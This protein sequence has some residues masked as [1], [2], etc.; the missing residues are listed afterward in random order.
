MADCGRSG[1]AVGY[2]ILSTF[3]NGPI[4]YGLRS[5]HTQNAQHTRIQITINYFL[6]PAIKPLNSPNEI[7]SE[8]SHKELCLFCVRLRSMIS[9]RVV[10]TDV[11][12][13][14]PYERTETIFFCMRPILIVLC[15]CCWPRTLG[16]FCENIGLGCVC[17][18]SA[19]GNFEMW[20]FRWPQ[21]NK[22]DYT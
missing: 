13:T 19:G 20:N 10:G 15:G 6:N 7:T 11:A 14:L 16:A 12:P 22:W 1:A 3:T 17:V 2:R 18:C 9:N 4:L 8:M 5:T 21:K